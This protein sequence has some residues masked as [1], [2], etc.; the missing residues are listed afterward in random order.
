MEPT[1]TEVIDPRAGTIRVFGD[2]TSAAA[3]GLRSTV[4]G[5]CRVG[6]RHV[7][8]DMS[9]VR[10]MESG[11]LAVLARL[12]EQLGVRGAEVHVF[13]AGEELCVFGG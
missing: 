8:L 13:I 11:A 2:L 3:H 4:V 7:V 12:Q 9:E 5:L 10:F 6:H 1:L